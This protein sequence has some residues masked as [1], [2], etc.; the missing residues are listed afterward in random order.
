MGRRMA[1]TENPV[2]IAA[3]VSGVIGLLPKAG[4]YVTRRSQRLRAETLKEIQA[5]T[6]GLDRLCARQETEIQRLND[7]LDL[8][9]N[10]VRELET[11][12]RRAGVALPEPGRP[13]RHRREGGE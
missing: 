10:Y 4:E 1:W 7:A 13:R 2:V 5:R 9:R 11:A 3:L 8:L 6:D 12:L